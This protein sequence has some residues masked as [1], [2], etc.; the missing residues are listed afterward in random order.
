MSIGR[1]VSNSRTIEN[2][3][4]MGDRGAS[5][6]S[7]MNPNRNDVRYNFS[8][9]PFLGQLELSLH[10]YKVSLTG[11]ESKAFANRNSALNLTSSRD[12]GGSH[13]QNLWRFQEPLTVFGEGYRFAVSRSCDYFKVRVGII[14]GEMDYFVS[15]VSNSRGSSEV[16][17]DEIFPFLQ[18]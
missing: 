12:F 6:R 17:T 2:Y 5:P 11:F 16:L 4:I 9:A 7:S 1:R 15:R 3:I 8:E 18:S 10:P 14:L 13:S